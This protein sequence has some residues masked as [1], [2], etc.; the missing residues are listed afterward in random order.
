MARANIALVRLAGNFVQR[1][2]GLLLR[3][4]HWH[5][6]S[7]LDIRFG[8]L[9]RC[10]SSGEAPPVQEPARKAKA[11]S[12]ENAI[13]E[14]NADAKEAEAL[15]DVAADTSEASKVK[16]LAPEPAS[17]QT[18]C[19]AARKQVAPDSKAAVQKAEAEVAGEKKPAMPEAEGVIPDP[20]TAAELGSDAHSVQ[21]EMA[22]VEHEAGAKTVAE[23]DVAPAEVGEVSSMV[24][25]AAAKAAE[26]KAARVAA[27][28]AVKEGVHTLEAEVVELKQMLA[29]FQE[30][31]ASMKTETGGFRK[32]LDRLVHGRGAAAEA[33]AAAQK[34]SQ[35]LE[36][37]IDE[38]RL[39]VQGTDEALTSALKAER[40]HT[41]A[42][43]KKYLDKE[44]EAAVPDIVRRAAR[45]MASS[46]TSNAEQNQLLQNAW[47]RLSI[48]GWWVDQFLFRLF[49]IGSALYL[50]SRK[51]EVKAM[52]QA[53]MD[54][55]RGAAQARKD[56]W[57]VLA[58][59]YTRPEL[60]DEEQGL[61]GYTEVE[62]ERIHAARNKRRM[63]VAERVER[64]ML[65]DGCGQ[66]LDLPAIPTQEILSELIELRK[67]MAELEAR[68]S[69]E[70]RNVAATVGRA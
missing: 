42:V 64:E 44:S 1:P 32:M 25:D 65:E 20:A 28:K 13:K 49:Q 7:H 52:Y 3:P 12:L 19:E 67:Q 50:W 31:H 27:E 6:G 57:T 4:R 8:P 5:R 9:R 16:P 55:E 68:L 40:E 51:E 45:W 59:S 48:W 69:E 36:N 56:A 24:V 17:T 54:A 2:L 22:A 46:E 53:S 58:P 14:L 47:Q 15:A 70:V 21:P 63:R 33:D 60:R 61:V 37:K 62:V 10:I 11:E 35:E 38:M 23:G 34:L 43:L 41:T 30:L 18:E 39:A 29:Q 26:T 66:K